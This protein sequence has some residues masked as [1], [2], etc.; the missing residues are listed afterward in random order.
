MRT[1]L[2]AVRARLRRAATTVLLLSGCAACA[3]TPGVN[4][5]DSPTRVQTP[6]SSVAERDHQEPPTAAT[7][8]PGTNSPLP[9]D[10]DGH[11]SACKLLRAS[12]VEQVSGLNH[13]AIAA[14]NATFCAYQDAS[15]GM[16]FRL[17]VNSYPEAA[18]PSKVLHTALAPYGEA[19]PIQGLA[20]GAGYVPDTGN[21]L[22]ASL[23]IVTSRRDSSVVLLVLAFANT[24]ANPKADL[25]ALGEV[26]LAQLDRL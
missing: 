4:Y 14:D 7:T 13:L 15:G 23:F 3:G 11:S 21:D 8:A 2:L 18:R 19:E 5:L 26:A 17:T 10:E 24:I 16:L 20:D 22:P 25:M 12:D 6:L 9:A 1:H